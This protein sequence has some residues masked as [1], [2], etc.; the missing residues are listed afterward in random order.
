[1][2]R[3]DTGSAHW[4]VIAVLCFAI[5]GAWQARYMTRMNADY[6]RRV[7]TLVRGLAAAHKLHPTKVIVLK[8]T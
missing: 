8:G 5:P 6:S 1:M 4:P 3:R 7:R 2:A